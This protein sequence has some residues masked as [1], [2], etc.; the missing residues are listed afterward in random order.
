MIK[1]NYIAILGWINYEKLKWLQNC[2]PDVPGLVH[3]L[4]YTTNYSRKLVH[5][6]NLWDAIL[7]NR[8]I[9]DI[10]SNDYIDPETY[11][12]DHLIPLL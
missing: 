3:K 6:R 1:D 9:I 10:F 11:D 4:S 8:P 7:S 5:V 2:N 12:I